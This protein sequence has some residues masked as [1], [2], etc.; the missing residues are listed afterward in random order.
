MRCNPNKNSL[1]LT[2]QYKKK[3]A[4][5]KTGR[6]IEQTFQKRIYT[7]GQHAPIKMLNII[8]HQE[9]QIKTTVRYHCAFIRVAKIGKTDNTKG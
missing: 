1:A 4:Q 9:V 8:S 2:T 5:P 6:R 7:N 3:T